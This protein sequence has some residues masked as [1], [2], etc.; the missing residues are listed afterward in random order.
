MRDAGT[1]TP[2]ST[3]V[4][5]TMAEEP[6]YVP[7]EDRERIVAYQKYNSLYWS[8][9]RAV[10]IVRDA[11]DGTPLY[12]PRPKMIVDTTAHYLLKGL[13]IDLEDPESQSELNRFLQAFFDREAF[14]ARFNIA[15]LKGVALG[16]WIFHI[17]ADPLAPP[18]RRITLNTVDPAAY[19]PE[20]HPDDQ[21]TRVGVRLM[22]PWVDPADTSKTLV[23]VLYYFFDW[24]NP[25]DRRV[26]REEAIWEVE[27]WWNQAK[28][29]KYKNL[30]P[31]EP[32]DE[33]ITE[34][35][36]YHFRNAEWDGF[37]FGN[38][39]LKGVEKIFRGIDQ[40]ISDEE[41]ALALVGLGVYATDAGRPTVNGREV[42]WVVSPG[43]VLEVPGATMIKRLEGI[44]SVTPVQ[45][46]L[47]YLD[48]A[49]KEAT[50]TSDIALGVIDAQTAESGIALAIKF[51]PTLAKI[52][53]RDQS[54]LAKL[55]Q[56]W[57]DLT[58]WFRVFESVDFGDTLI[59]PRIGE[60]L[61][62]NHV[63]VF[64]E[65]NNL[66]DRKIISAQFYRDECERRLGYN[67]PEN[68]AKQILDEQIAQLEIMQRQM[69]IQAS[70]AP[71]DSN[72][73][74]PNQSNNKNRVNES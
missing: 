71:P 68:I 7:E 8:E 22:E 63:Q 23:K 33:R 37:L 16:D 54:G 70:V 10:E 27:D 29:K 11:E 44:T 38:S 41:I 51:I 25:A 50:G 48:S 39:E 9:D 72:G 14:L 31:L 74:Q 52:E 12:V 65:L 30:L 64:N 32:L 35:P 56:M 28:A 49:L 53:Y 45:D 62:V 69:Q 2:W 13:T 36:V 55:T 20:Y 6:T 59:L 17:T 57:Y 15:K 60:K 73:D 19:F 3:I 21:E 5:V 4:P 42:D 46:H 43:T 24:Q 26:W 34:I 18:E 1:V 67:F 58:S 61:P 47:R 66:F 40:A